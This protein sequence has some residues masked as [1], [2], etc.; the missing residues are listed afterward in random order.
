MT[1]TL[2]RPTDAPS[3]A[4]DFSHGAEWDARSKSAPLNA[5]GDHVTIQK[6]WQELIR[7]L[8]RRRFEAQ[9]GPARMGENSDDPEKLARVDPA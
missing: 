9:I 4:A 2:I 5:M 7:D 3:T 8:Q 6:N 1:D